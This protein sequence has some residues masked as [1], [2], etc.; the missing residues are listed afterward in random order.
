MRR[1]FHEDFVTIVVRYCLLSF[2]V[3]SSVQLQKFSF[4]NCLFHFVKSLIGRIQTGN[5]EMAETEKRL[6]FELYGIHWE[7]I[8][9]PTPRSLIIH[10]DGFARSSRTAF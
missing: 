1:V 5:D 9:A 10:I 3:S 8:M 6:N 7:P 4:V 2:P